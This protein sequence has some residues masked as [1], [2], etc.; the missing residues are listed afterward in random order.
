MKKELSNFLFAQ[1]LINSECC[2]DVTSLKALQFLEL[3]VKAEKTTCCGATQS[4]QN[5]VQNS[6]FLLQILLCFMNNIE[7]PKD[8]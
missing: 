1:C 5:S 8:F 7:I 3:R 4:M 2:H 6:E